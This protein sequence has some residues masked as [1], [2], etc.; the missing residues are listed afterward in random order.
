M[1]RLRLM[2]ARAT[3]VLS[4]GGIE[5]F[6][7]T[8]PGIWWISPSQYDFSIVDDSCKLHH[9]IPAVFHAAHRSQRARLSLVGQAT[10]R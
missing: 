9:S 10:S 6:T 3:W 8:L 7:F 4:A 2:L 1:I 5:L